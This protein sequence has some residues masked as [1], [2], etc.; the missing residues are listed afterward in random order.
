[1]YQ[2]TWMHIQDLHT[3]S[4]WFISNFLSQFNLIRCTIEM[5]T[6]CMRINFAQVSNFSLKRKQICIHI[7]EHVVFPCTFVNNKAFMW[8]FVN[9]GQKGGGRC[10]ELFS[11]FCVY[12]VQMSIYYLWLHAC[13]Q[14]LMIISKQQLLFFSVSLVNRNALD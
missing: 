13:L 9:S 10:K 12:T 8:V 14:I 3:D 6:Y 4:E 7:C 5:C 2:S 11:C 1:M